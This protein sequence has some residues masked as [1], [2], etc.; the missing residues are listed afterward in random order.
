MQNLNLLAYYQMTC[1]PVFDLMSEKQ[2]I[3]NHKTP[4]LAAA[5]GC[6]SNEFIQHDRD[7]N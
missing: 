5:R 1:P 2:R 6:W 4:P 7:V 3:M